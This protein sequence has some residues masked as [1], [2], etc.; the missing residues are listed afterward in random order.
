[1]NL[2]E[3]AKR[4][5]FPTLTE[6]RSKAHQLLLHIIISERFLPCCDA[7]VIDTLTPL[8]S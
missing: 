3:G 5:N 4:E 6:I 8:T 1:M 2:R 7:S